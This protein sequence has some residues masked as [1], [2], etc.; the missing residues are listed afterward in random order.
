[1]P[2]LAELFRLAEVCSRTKG[3]DPSACGLAR[4]AR[5]TSEETE[6]YRHGQDLDAAAAG[7]GRGRFDTATR[8][9]NIEWALDIDP[10]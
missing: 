1:M 3:R 9:P 5:H 6:G 4:S 8:S 2:F 10:M 7:A